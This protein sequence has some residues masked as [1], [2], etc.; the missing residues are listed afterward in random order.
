MDYWVQ[1]QP[2]P[3]SKF[4]DSQGYIENSCFKQTNKQE[5]AY[6][7]A[8]EVL[9]HWL[10]YGLIC[11]F[12]C[13][14]FFRDRVSLYSHGCLGAHSVDQA[15]LQLRNLP[16]SASRMLRLKVCAHHYPAYVT[17]LLFGS[18]LGMDWNNGCI[19]SGLVLSL[20][21]TSSPSLSH[22]RQGLYHW[23]HPHPLTGRF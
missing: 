12:V 1:G 22:F 5:C 10:C 16:A 15:G 11:L 8:V 18:V 20:S 7:E 3:Q 6:C 14:V 9:G 19:Y 13:F 23:A 21:C 2:G 4:Q 17:V